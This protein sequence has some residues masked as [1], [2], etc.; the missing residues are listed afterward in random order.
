MKPHVYQNIYSRL[1]LLGVIDLIQ[2]GVQARKLKNEP[3]MPL[4]YDL[5]NKYENEARISLAHNFVQNGDLMADPDMEISVNLKH[6]IAEALTFQ[7]DSLGVY[8]V[9]YPDWPDKNWFYLRERKGQ[10]EFLAQ[11]LTNLINQGFKFNG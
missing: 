2:R 5:L 3:C 6:G 7:Q 11:W 8:R 4:S 10:N 1:K 9:V